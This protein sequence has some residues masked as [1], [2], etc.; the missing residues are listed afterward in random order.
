MLARPA[1]SVSGRVARCHGLHLLDD[2]LDC[3]GL[4]VRRILVLHQ[5]ALDR[6]PQLRTHVIPD[7]PVG[8]GVAL[9]HL[10]EF[11]SDLRQDILAL[12]FD[13]RLVGADGVVEGEFVL[14]QWRAEVLAAVTFGSNILRHLNELGDD[15]SGRKLLIGVTVHQLSN[16]LGERALADEVVARRLSGLFEEKVA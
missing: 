9:Q 2:E 10:D 14:R 5:E 12:Q 13:G 8:L 7:E 6:R 15:L 11:A 4:L 16:P 3:L 1:T